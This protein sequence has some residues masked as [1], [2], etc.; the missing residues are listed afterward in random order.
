MVKIV[1]PLG[2]TEA[3]GRVS[4]VV[5]TRG[6]TGNLLRRYHT[7]GP[8]LPTG[9][10]SAMAKLS[11]ASHAWNALPRADQLTWIAYH[12]SNGKAR[13]AYIAGY[14]NLATES[15]GLPY[16]PAPSAP[17]I[18]LTGAWAESEPTPPRSITI[19]WTPTE[20]V[21]SAVYLDTYN[22]TLRRTTLDV[23]KYAHYS[24]ASYL[25]GLISAQVPL[26]AVSTF[27]RLRI[28][29]L[30]SGSITATAFFSQDWTDA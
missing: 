27:A 18:N 12:G 15:M 7:R 13:E 17:N 29:D 2:S 5:F 20:M 25:D 4:G 8:W 22:S 16:G 21:D 26:W 3:T 24:I 10:Q 11:D 6:K 14:I 30:N 1:G 28:V 19:F 23:R 9:K